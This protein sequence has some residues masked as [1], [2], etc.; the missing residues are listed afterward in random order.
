MSE[1]TDDALDAV[2]AMTVT[3]PPMSA[4]LEAELGALAPVTPR[5]PL[6]QVAAFGLTSLLFGSLLVAAQRVRADASELPRVWLIGA[7]AAWFLGFGLAT[8]FALVPKAGGMTPRW[9][10]AIAT[11]AITSVAF[12]ILGLSV[13]PSGPHS[14]HY[15]MPR[16]MHGQGCFWAGLATAGVPIVLGAI[17]L[18]GAI[19]V[20][21]RWIA[22][23][24]GAAGGCLGG[25]VLH[26]HCPI[27][28]GPH[29]GIM[30]GGVVVAAALLAA[31]LVPR[32]TDRP[33]RG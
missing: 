3:A 4:A 17:F 23:A 11:T 9:R 33:Y 6:R 2:A 12:V 27:A 32:A 20:F 16:L 8:Y 18:R 24:L 10:A 26:M 14:L 30:H 25:M 13:H 5:R 28:D 19:P 15:G 22:A 1:P 29:I 21:S 31:L 7:G